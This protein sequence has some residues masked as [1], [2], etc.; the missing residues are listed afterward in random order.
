MTTA[1]IIG[2]GIAGTATAMA[3]H[4]AGIAA[5]V[6][7]A[8]P[9]TADDVGAF[10]TMRPNGMDALATLGVSDAVE[11]AGFPARTVELLDS[12]GTRL[13]EFEIANSGTTGRGSTTLTRARL[14]RVLQ[15]AATDRGV[16]IEHGKRLTACVTDGPDTGV[17]AT[18][19]D[20][21]SARAD[22]VIGADGIHSTT[23]QLIDRRPHDHDRPAWTSCTATRR[24]RPLRQ[25]RP[26][27][28]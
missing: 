22:M 13:G 3:L 23:R 8:H 15:D 9:R 6:Y 18:F 4:K 2:A 20:G 24:T 1:L 11:Q 14:Y 28:A 19:A 25:P 5:T 27:T 10:L 17:T 16:A 21:R 26:R 7:E 12:A